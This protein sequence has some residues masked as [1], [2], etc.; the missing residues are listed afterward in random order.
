[1]CVNCG[2]VAMSECTG[3]HKVNYCSPFC[4]RKVRSA[5]ALIL[6]LVEGFLLLQVSLDLVVFWFFLQDW[7]EHQ[8]ICCQTSGGVVV[9]E[10]K[11]ITAMDMDK[12][13]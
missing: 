5:A 4:Q 8:H 1:M 3:C 2:R 9:H 7:K 6:E 13:K 11:P 10:D 12:V